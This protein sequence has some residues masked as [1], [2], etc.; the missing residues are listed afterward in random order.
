MPAVT[1][2]NL[3]CRRGPDFSLEDLSLELE[4]GSLN[5]IMGP[6]GCGKTTLLRCLEGTLTPDEGTIR[7]EGAVRF[8]PQRPETVLLSYPTPR[9]YLLEMTRGLPLRRLGETL[10][11]FGLDALADKPMETLSGGQLQ[12]TAVAGALASGADILALDEPTAQLDPITAADLI[13]LLR[14]LCRELNVTVLL[15]EHRT[16][17]LFSAADRVLVLDH[18]RAAAWGT[19]REAARTLTQTR[20]PLTPLLP[21]AAQLWAAAPEGDC[22]ITMTEGRAYLSR[23]GL[24]PKQPVP[25]APLSKIP[26]PV[27][28]AE[29]IWFRYTKDGQD[30][31][32]ELSLRLAPGETLVVVGSNGAGKSTLIRCLTGS[33]RPYSGKITGS[34][35]ELPQDPRPLF[36]GEP[37]G[38]RLRENPYLQALEL[39]NLLDRTTEELSCGQVQKAALALV[40]AQQ[41]SVLVLDEPTRGMD[42][43]SRN[44]LAQLLAEDRRKGRSHLIVSH[45]TEF[46]A[47]VSN[48]AAY[49]FDGAIIAQAEP[50]HFF[51][52]NLAY[53]A[54]AGRIAGM[55]FPNVI[56]VAELLEAAASLAM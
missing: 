45:D 18:G 47:M 29:R 13:G 8:V 46:C 35:L 9:A 2:N 6:S 34:A 19:P 12:L 50:L 52:G 49:L 32:K 23:R 36:H 4:A 27:L 43:I 55:Q 31:L 16:E 51:R 38:K 3:T 40:L 42:P 5:L 20:H 17:S 56:T 53:T 33:L 14:R 1:V 22:P 37:I 10:G 7:L 48:R 11:F 15:S 21:A 28:S 44:V 25:P 41:A 26:H 39:E 54:A 24:P 30:I